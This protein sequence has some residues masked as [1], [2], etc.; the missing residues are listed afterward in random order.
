MGWRDDPYRSIDIRRRFE[1]TGRGFEGEMIAGGHLALKT[2]NECVTP[3][4]P[5][6]FELIE[7]KLNLR[8]ATLLENGHSTLYVKVNGDAFALSHLRSASK[9]RTP[10]TLSLWADAEPLT[11]A[12]FVEGCP[13][14][15]WGDFVGDLRQEEE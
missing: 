14:A 1:A 15:L 9:P 2:F 3:K 8:H 4:T 13:V 7:G 10:F 6:I 12:F 11:V 5:W